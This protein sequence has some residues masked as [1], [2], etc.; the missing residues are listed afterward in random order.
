M[1]GTASDDTL[2]TTGEEWLDG[3]L[4]TIYDR[5]EADDYDA[6]IAWAKEKGVEA[7]RNT[8]TMY[9]RGDIET[10]EW[11]FDMLASASTR[12]AVSDYP[13][14]DTEVAPVVNCVSDWHSG[15][16]RAKALA[17]SRRATTLVDVIELAH[18]QAYEAGV[19]IRSWLYAEGYDPETPIP[20]WNDDA[21]AW[22]I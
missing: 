21:Q 19:P 13:G 12:L 20:T 22:E 5:G 6:L 14:Y 10:T 18:A 8:V 3:L 15:E 17:A 11:Y 7:I 16:A 1:E 2:A 9:G 4:R